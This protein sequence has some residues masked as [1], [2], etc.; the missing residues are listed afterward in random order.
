MKKRVLVMAS[1]LAL[2][3]VAA[4]QVAQAQQSMV[5]NIPFEFVVGNTTLPA[6][7]YYVESLTGQSA[8]VL[9]QRANPSASAVVP[10]FAT[11]ALEPKSDSKLIFNRYENSYFLSQ[12][13]TAG[14]SRGRQLLKSGREK[15]IAKIARIETQGQVTLVARLSPVH[16]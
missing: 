9:K 15:E 1:L 4:I 7:E 11:Q 10:T 13:W 2:S 16:P 8:L 14:N 3:I 5:V 6:G 12:F